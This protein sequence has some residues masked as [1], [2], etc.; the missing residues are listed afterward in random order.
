M[1]TERNT[2]S[3]RPAVAMLACGVLALAGCAA[4]PTPQVIRETV[5]VEVEKPVEKTV[6]QTV[7]V[8]ATSAPAAPVA[9]WTA[10]EVA[11]ATG[12]DAC[13]Q[14]ATLPKQFKESWK[15]GFVSPNKGH[16]FFGV[17]SQAMSDASKF[18][19]VE[20]VEVDVAGD[21]TKKQDLLETLLLSNPNVVGNGG[22]G[23]DI[24]EGLAARAQEA[25][26]TFIG[27]DNG[28]SAYSPYVYG[29][30]DAFAGKTGAELLIKGVEERQ[31][32]DW[33]DKELFFI[34]FTHKGIPACVNRT[35]GAVQA[36]KAHFKLDD[37]HVLLADVATGQSATDLIKAILTANPNAVF[38]MIPCWDGLGIEPYN[39]AKDSGREADIMLVTLGGDKPPADLLVTKPQGYY[40]YVEFQPYC[41]GWGWVEASL[42]T[43]EGLPFQPYQTRRVTTQADIDARYRELYGEPPVP[44]KQP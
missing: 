13:P 16:P 17:W 6:E 23:P 32:A 2:V 4:P 9:S 11:A 28:P 3:L 5:V 21:Y 18:Y 29:I 19:G 30:P 36:F 7:V 12:K 10:E 20:F 26:V 44:T 43:L 22:T 41:E 31:Q 39:A 37:E 40:G 34:E 8:E 42:A 25:G 27:I 15:L 14:L 24:Y 38:A 1:N 35:G 33:K